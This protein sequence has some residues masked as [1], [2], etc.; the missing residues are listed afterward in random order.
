M[1]TKRAWRFRK[2]SEGDRISTLK[3]GCKI[4]VYQNELVKFCAGHDIV[5]SCLWMYDADTSSYDTECDGKFTFETGEWWQNSYE[6]C[7]KCGGKIKDAV[8]RENR[9]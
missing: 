4:D 7:P 2:G 9:T 1:K 6:Y 5:R 8:I 3:C